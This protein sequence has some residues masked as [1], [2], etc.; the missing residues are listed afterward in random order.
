VFFA[1]MWTPKQNLS[2]LLV[3]TAYAVLFGVTAI[4]MFRWD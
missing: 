2:P 1:G 3:M 4:R